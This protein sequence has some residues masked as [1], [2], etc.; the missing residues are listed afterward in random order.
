MNETANALWPR[1]LSPRVEKIVKE[2][3]SPLAHRKIHRFKM[4]RVLCILA[5]FTFIIRFQRRQYKF[6][7]FLGNNQSPRKPLLPSIAVA[8]DLCKSDTTPNTII[9]QEPFGFE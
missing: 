6:K 4:F 1:T 7:I 3:L 5:G 9:K 8:N 2:D